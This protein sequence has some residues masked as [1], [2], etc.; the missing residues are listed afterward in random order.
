M[1]SLINRERKSRGFRPGMSSTSL[2][3]LEGAF[4]CIA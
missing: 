2:E 1:G 4:R 3:N